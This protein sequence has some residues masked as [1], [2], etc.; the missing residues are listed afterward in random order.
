MRVIVVIPRAQFNYKAPWTP[1][2]AMSVSTVL[3]QA[4]NDVTF[5]DRCFN[6]KSIKRILKALNPDVVCLSVASVRQVD[7]AFVVS[8]VAKEFAFPVVWGGFFATENYVDILKT[9]VVDFVSLGEGELNVPHLIQAI[10][11]KRDFRDIPGIAYLQGNN[12]MV[13][14]P[15]ALSDLK[16]LPI[17]D[18]TICNPENYLH[19]YLFCKRMMYLYASKGCPSECTFCSNPRFHC[20]TYRTRPIE[21]VIEEIKYLH[22]HHG[23]D[24]VYFSDEC[25]YLKRSD[26]LTF[27]RRLEE[28]NLS[29]F[30]GCELRFGIYNE[31]DLQYMYDHG[32]RWIFFGL[33]SGDPEMLK[34]IKKNISIA[35]IRKTVSICN[36]IGIV[37]ISSFIIGYPDESPEQLKNTIDLVLEI[38][39]GISVCNIYT[40]VANSE[41]M[42]QLIEKKQ[43]SIPSALDVNQ[44]TLAGES[45]TYRCN[46]IPYKDLKVIRSWLMWHEFKKKSI[47]NQSKSFEIAFNAVRETLSNIKRNG[48]QQLIPSLFLAAGEVVPVF[49]Y[50]HFYPS[51]RKRYH[52]K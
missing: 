9:G 33:E 44:R 26:M 51:I 37:A 21:Y 20:H 29:I 4:G 38:N 8:K 50:A 34:K 49:W 27:C 48:L 1:L 28:E 45:S 25:W 7:D 16:E 36:K 24:G 23:L 17:L 40:P 52:L 2:G 12:A 18:F 14:L 15:Y 31:D 41:M 19:P 3:R 30:W 22:E 39:S 11:K 35:Q 5:I 6:R 13:T 10:D 47:T 42:D 32:C 43:Y 46:T